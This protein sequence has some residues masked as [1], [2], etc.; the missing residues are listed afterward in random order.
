MKFQNTRT[1]DIKASKPSLL[2]ATI[3]ICFPGTAFSANQIS[4]EELLNLEYS[5]GAEVWSKDSRVLSEHSA[6][7]RFPVLAYAKALDAEEKALT[8]SVNK[9]SNLSSGVVT[10]AT[11]I[12]LAATA[13]GGGKYPTGGTIGNVATVVAVA[14]IGLNILNSIFSSNENSKYRRDRL[15]EMRSPSLYLVRSETDNKGET[16]ETSHAK[17]TEIMRSIQPFDCD[18]SINR[19]GEKWIGAARKELFYVRNIVCADDEARVKRALFGGPM[20]ND[21]L[22]QSFR[23]IQENETPP[24]S[25]SIIGLH[26]LDQMRYTTMLDIQEADD[27][28]QKQLGRLAYEK[29]Q[30]FIPPEWTAVYTAPN[31]K[32]VWA[33]FVARNGVTIEFPM[34]KS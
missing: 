9:E 34:P 31:P 21:R 11:N 22:I 23:Y 3:W 15:W 19:F 13:L 27:E 32:G 12:A 17:V 24:R 14:D 29:A 20:T 8:E 10:P 5:K 2:I 26:S 16:L 33:V 1:G 4:E 6:L 30:N 18:V 7:T 28:Q 25:V